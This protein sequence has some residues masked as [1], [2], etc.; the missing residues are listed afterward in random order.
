MGITW[1][2]TAVALVM[3]A[4]RLYGASIRRG[5]LR[6][7]FVWV[8]FACVSMNLKLYWDRTEHL[9]GMWP[10]LTISSHS[11][12]FSRIGNASLGSRP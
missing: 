3:V 8:S 7:D 2:E 6:W 11:V 4:A 9:L 5:E 10:D 12:R 1:A